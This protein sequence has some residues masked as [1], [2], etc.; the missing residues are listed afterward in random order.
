VCLRH[1]DAPHKEDLMV[2][3]IRLRS[4]TVRTRHDKP[5]ATEASLPYDPAREVLQRRRELEQGK[6]GR[7]RLE[8]GR[9]GAYGKEG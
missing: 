4:A 3:Q 2:D 7:G 1:R 6:L 9:R 8:G 5:I